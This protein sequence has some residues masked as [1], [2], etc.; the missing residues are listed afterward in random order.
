MKRKNLIATIAFFITFSSQGQVTLDY[1]LPPNSILNE[2]IPTPKSI[3]G[4]EVGEWHVSH[5]KLVQ[6][7]YALAEA[8]DRIEI[9]QYASSHENRP[10]LTLKIS[11]AKNLQNLE[12]I[13][14]DHLKLSDYK[15]SQNLDPDDMPLVTYLGYSVHGNE[16]SGSNAALLVAYYLAA[17]EN[18]EVEQWLDSTVILLDPSYNPDGLNRFAAWVNSRRGIHLVSDPN[19]MEQNE[20]WPQARTNHYWFDLNRDWLPVQHPESQGRVAQYHKWKPNVLTDHHEM[21]TNGTYFFQP[22]IPSRNNPLTPKN[23]IVLT[24]KI[25]A[26]HAKALDEIGSLYYSK[27]SFDDF[28]IGKGSSFPDVNGGIGILFEQASARGHSQNSSNGKLT[29][30]FAIKNH[31]T[32]SLSTLRASNI[33]RIELLEHQRQF[34][35]DIPGMTDKLP[36]KAYV[37][38][39]S[40]DRSRL[41][42][43]LSILDTHQINVYKLNSAFREFDPK[44]SYIIPLKQNQF[45]MIQAAFETR[46]RFQD[47]LFYDVSAWTLPL[48]FDL[49]YKTI[50]GKDF[51]NSLI[52]KQVK[53]D[54]LPQINTGFEPSTF[55]Y[56]FH[57]L[58]AKASALL[59]DIQKLGLKSKVTTE[60]WTSNKGESFERGAIVIPV[61]NQNLSGTEIHQ[62]LIKLADTH[63]IPISSLETGS[64]SGYM[65]G[66]PKLKSIAPIKPVLL[67]GGGVNAYEAGEVWHLLD[68]RMGVALPMITQSRFNTIDLSKYNVLIMVG[69]SY[70]TLAQA[71]IKTWVQQGGRVIATKS[72][73]KWASD[74][75]LSKIKYHKIVKDSTKKFLR[76]NERAKV[77]GAQR[78]GGAIFET[79]LDLTH[80]LCFG[81]EDDLLPIFKRGLQIMEL[82]K[83]PYSQPVHYTETPL[84]AGYI[85][86][87]NLKKLPNTPAVGLSSFGKG[88]VI[89]I[90]DNP[91]FRGYWHGTHRLFLNALFFGGIVDS[92]SAQ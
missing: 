51:S 70:G 59:F 64:T 9:E 76:Y 56:A 40:N 12:K 72:A 3:L 67:I 11:S 78:I 6:Y 82:A 20:P 65:L 24:E 46:T 57:W 22:G 84:L 61:Q 74:A 16:A 39:V 36:L 10:L 66:S 38:Q 89:S 92:G 48:A 53:A 44:N 88:L 83:N 71:K 26:Y 27:E 23:N 8:S 49:K 32:T 52:G 25:A 87:K 31:F 41:K 91:N 1:Y 15:Q 54:D 35:A 60:P 14:T 58:D 4:Y 77:N 86:E 34:Y 5:D 33:L 2:E 85:S 45:R 29:F 73:G 80:P 37:F 43:F 50:E 55:A 69:G 81:Y 19:N 42:A 21:G 30:P 63:S 18:K 7:M 68:Q 90:N 13:R 62:A 79:Q 75:G 47:S 28:Y 17:A